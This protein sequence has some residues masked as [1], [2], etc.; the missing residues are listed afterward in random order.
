MIIIHITSYV[1]Y[2]KGEGEKSPP[3]HFLSLH[4][5]PQFRTPPNSSPHLKSSPLLF[6]LISPNSLLLNFSIFFTLYFLFFSLNP[7][8]LP[9]SILPS[10]NLAGYLRLEVKM[11]QTKCCFLQVETGKKHSIKKLRSG[12][13]K[14]I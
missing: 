2:V 7:Y 11:S 10:L 5:I 6:H 12:K 1:T 3:P 13:H 14:N 4:L 8:I 9:P